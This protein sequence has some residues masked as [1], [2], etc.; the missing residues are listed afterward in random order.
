M[1]EKVVERLARLIDVKSLVTLALVIVLCCMTVSGRETGDLFNN[2]V[3]LVLGFFFGKNLKAEENKD[4]QENNGV[5]V[6]VA[7]GAVGDDEKNIDNKD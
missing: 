6:S 5:G 7:G 2:S 3:M 1:A 4:K